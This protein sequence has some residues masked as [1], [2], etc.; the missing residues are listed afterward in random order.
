MLN[1]TLDEFE[2]LGLVAELGVFL[3]LSEAPT[4]ASR[5]PLL[6]GCPCLGC[7]TSGNR[8]FCVALL[9]QGEQIVVDGLGHVLEHSVI[10]CVPEQGLSLLLLS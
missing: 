7:W 4:A 8:L 5:G 9:L 1:V 10:D 3:Y 2:E 6:I